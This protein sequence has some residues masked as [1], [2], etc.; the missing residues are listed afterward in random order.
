[1]QTARGN[2]RKKKKRTIGKVRE[3]SR[4][5]K[6]KR[7]TKTKTNAE[8]EQT[9][10]KLRWRLIKQDY[11]GRTADNWRGKKKRRREVGSRGDLSQKLDNEPGHKSAAA[12]RRQLQSENG[13]GWVAKGL[14]G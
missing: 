7:Q 9:V 11:C 5:N 10:E 12:E 6:G 14:R 4:K 13:D 1:V 3:K 8:K 2:S